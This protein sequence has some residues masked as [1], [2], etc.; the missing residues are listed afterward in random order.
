VLCKVSSRDLVLC[1]VSSRDL[2]LCKVSSSD[3][4]LCKVS[5]SD[6]VLCKV[7]FDIG[8]QGKPFEWFLKSQILTIVEN[9][10]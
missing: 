9:S 6:L 1:K 8:H 7:S 3:L 4:V 5:S 2:V 10:C